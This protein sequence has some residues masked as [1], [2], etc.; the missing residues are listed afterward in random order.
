MQYGSRMKFGFF[1]NHALAGARAYEKTVKTSDFFINTHEVTNDE[2][3]EFVNEYKELMIKENNYDTLVFDHSVWYSSNTYPFDSI[4]ININS[5]LW[6]QELSHIMGDPMMQYYF[7]HEAFNK[8][9]VTG[10]SYEQCLAFVD[11]KNNKLSEKLKQLGFTESW[12]KFKI[13]SRDEWYAAAYGFTEWFRGEPIT[14][15]LYPWDGHQLHSTINGDYYANFGQIV[16]ENNASLKGFYE[17]GFFYTS[18]IKSF[19]PNSYG[20]YDMGGNISEWTSTTVD[21]DSIAS[22]YKSFYNFECFEGDTV[23]YNEMN[24]PYPNWHLL[25]SLLEHHKS[26]QSEWINPNGWPDDN[27]SLV[28]FLSIAKIYEK[29]MET[30]NLE[31]LEKYSEFQIVKGGN[32]LQGPIYMQISSDQAYNKKE[33]SVSVGMRLA[34]EISPQVLEFLGDNF[35]IFHIKK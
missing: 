4:D 11:W 12:G 35:G 26:P 2:Y 16:D 18:P 17:D 31:L 32:W 22:Y 13:P 25:D 5:T 14:R 29:P 21:Y 33:T 8:Y 15:R 19:E 3:R 27:R 23:L 6:N 30:H 34:L 7:K 24:K 28:T 10:I 9:P 20:L 1:D